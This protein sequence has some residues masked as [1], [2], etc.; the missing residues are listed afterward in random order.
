MCPAA[1]TTA[2]S[3]RVEIQYERYDGTETG[4]TINIAQKEGVERKC[5][6]M[7]TEGVH[8]KHDGQPRLGIGK[9]T[10]N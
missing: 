9:T 8:L 10:D 6:S 4:L 5:K 7:E 1:P 3:V 2:A